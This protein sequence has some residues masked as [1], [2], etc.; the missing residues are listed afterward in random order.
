MGAENFG[1]PKGEMMNTN[2]RSFFGLKKEPF[3][4]DISC[5]EILK[6]TELIDVKERFDYII[7]KPPNS[8]MSKN[9]LTISSGSGPS[10]LSPEKSAAANPPPSDMPQNTCTLPSTKAFT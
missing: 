7:R 10:V 4:S 2:Y 1:L 6:T 3:G 9:A 8:S 5:K